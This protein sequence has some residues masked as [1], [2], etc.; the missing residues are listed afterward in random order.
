MFFLFGTNSSDKTL[1]KGFFKCPNPN[2]TSIG[3]IQFYEEKQ[4]RQYATIF[5]IPIF[6][7]GGGNDEPWIECQECNRTY[8]KEV[9]KNN[10]YYLN[11]TLIEEI[12]PAIEIYDEFK[13]EEEKL[14]EKMIRRC[15]KCNTQIRLKER[16]SGAVTCPECEA[17]FYTSTE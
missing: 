3:G 8:Y 5:F 9:L 12:K 4:R 1:S 14:R 2:H 10:R 11:G 16:K 7:I 15:P 6:P 17:R 13:N